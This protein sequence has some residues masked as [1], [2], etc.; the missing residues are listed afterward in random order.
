MK[1]SKIEWTHHTF[2]PWW[3]C[4]KIS[5]GCRNCYAE[6]HSARVGYSSKG[7]QFP[8]WGPSSERRT[9]SDKHWLEPIKWNLKAQYAGGRERVFCGSM[10][11][12]MEDHRTAAFERPKLWE[13]IQQTPCL[14]WLLLT[15]RPENFAKYLPPSWL[16]QPRPNVWLMTTVESQ[17]TAWRAQELAKVPAVVR[18]L[19]CE[20]LLSHV[21]F[22]ETP[23]VW[24]HI[25]WVIAGGESGHGARPMQAD[26]ARSLR[27]QC[28]VAGVPFFFKQWGEHAPV[29]VLFPDLAPGIDS[30]MR[31]RKDRAGRLLDG[32]EWNEFPEVRR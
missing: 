20:P 3:G 2:N 18:G 8:I 12:I 17:D 32:R 19:S 21:D 29:N 1:N 27:D 6:S 15:K 4:T 16:Q 31:V 23:R 7:S 11:D 26:W 14:D 28:Q 13:L 5:E 30:L 10:C 25:H 24:D 9:M 22:S